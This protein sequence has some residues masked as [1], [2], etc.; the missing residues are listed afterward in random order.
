M[1]SYLK[2]IIIEHLNKYRLIKDSQYGFMSK[3]SCL[4]N[5]LIFLETVTDYIDKGCP[6]DALCLDFQKAFDKVPQCRLIEK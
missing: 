2:D 1:E 3:R 6:V 4:T 5:L